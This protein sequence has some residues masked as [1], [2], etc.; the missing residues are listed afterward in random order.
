LNEIELDPLTINYREQLIEIFKNVED[1][2]NREILEL[3]YD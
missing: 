3:N 2:F 1:P